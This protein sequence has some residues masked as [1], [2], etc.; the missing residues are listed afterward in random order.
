M[1]IFVWPVCPFI[2]AQ[3]LTNIRF[4]TVGAQPDTKGW[5]ESQGLHRVQ[6][7]ILLAV[8]EDGANHAAVSCS[9]AASP[10]VLLLV[11]AMLASLLSWAQR[12]LRG[13]LP[14]NSHCVSSGTLKGSWFDLIIVQAAFLSKRPETKACSQ[15]VLRAILLLGRRR[16]EV[17]QLHI[18]NTCWA[19]CR[20]LQLMFSRVGRPSRCVMSCSWT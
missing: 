8:E 15:P 2:G 19:A 4:T 17:K 9:Q 18:T 7:G 14:L 13:C 16:W 1:S 3:V 11:R 6:L 20:S 5:W 12:L 10:Q